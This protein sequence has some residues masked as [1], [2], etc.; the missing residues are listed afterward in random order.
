MV[1]STESEVKI[2]IFTSC[3]SRPSLIG[4]AA[5]PIQSVSNYENDI[6]NN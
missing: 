6:E 5:Y 4:W 2:P 3:S 1:N